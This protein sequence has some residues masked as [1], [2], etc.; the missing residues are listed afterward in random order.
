LRREQIDA[1]SNHPAFYNDEANYL[2]K[3]YRYDEARAIFEK[4]ENNRL[5][6]GIPWG[7]IDS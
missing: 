6:N 4:A 1:G 2:I 5:T 7:I 3:K